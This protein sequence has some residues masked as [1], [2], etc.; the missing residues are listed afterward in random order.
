MSLND[1]AKEAGKS[2]NHSTIYCSK[3]IVQR[4]NV[5]VTQHNVRWTETLKSTNSCPEKMKI[6][7]FKK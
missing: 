7:L 3:C 2:I 1:G 6:N 4:T 5:N